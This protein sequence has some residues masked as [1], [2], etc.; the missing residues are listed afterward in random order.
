MRNFLIF[1][2][3]VAV[4]ILGCLLHSH[5]SVLV[6]QQRQIHELNTKVE[7]K[8]KTASLELQEQCSKQ[9]R[10]QFAENGWKKEPIASF[11]N[12]YNLKMNKC[13]M[14]IESTTP[15]KPSDGTFFVSKLLFDAFEGK[16]YGEYDWRSDKVK[17]YWEVAPI[18]CKG[19]LL[20][21]EEKNCHSSDEFDEIV[22]LYM[23]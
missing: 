15:T 10:E 4:A 5:N 1:A 11:T 3:I 22:K 18:N 7:E 9:A 14:L 16:S 17:K 23:Q 20:S 21:G 2:L 19:T 13:F 12:H 8:T 6:D